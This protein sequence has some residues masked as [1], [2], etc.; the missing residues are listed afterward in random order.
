MPGNGRIVICTLVS[1]LLIKSTDGKYTAIREY[2]PF[3]TSVRKKLLET[4][5]EDLYPVIDDL[6]VQHGR[7]MIRDIEDRYRDGIISEETYRIL[8]AEHALA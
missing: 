1:Q 6:L 8:E 4:S 2:L 7:P 3:S 5:I